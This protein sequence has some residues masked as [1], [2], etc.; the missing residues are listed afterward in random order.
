MLWLGALFNLRYAADGHTKPP[1]EAFLHYARI[2]REAERLDFRSSNDAEEQHWGGLIKRTFGGRKHA[3]SPGDI[4]YENTSSYGENAK[5][6][7]P[8]E[9][10]TAAIPDTDSSGVGEFNSAEVAY[11]ALR[12]AS[13]QSVFYLIVSGPDCTVHSRI[14]LT[15]N[16]RLQIYWVPSESL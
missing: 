13:W 9:K 8:S 2:Q 12:M 5:H 14:E 11:K 4:L 3:G 10:A 16:V 15:F 6:D 7:R 1:F